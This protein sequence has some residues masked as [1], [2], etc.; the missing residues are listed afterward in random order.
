VVLDP[1]GRITK[2]FTDETWSVEELV[3]ALREAAK[4][5]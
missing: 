3:S 5:S 2:I 4:K 1:T